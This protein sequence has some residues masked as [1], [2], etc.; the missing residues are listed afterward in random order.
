M[1]KVS[2]F[3]RQETT[4]LMTS[5]AEADRRFG[6]KRPEAGVWIVALALRLRGSLTI[7]PGHGGR[8]E[9][10]RSRDFHGGLG[11]SNPVAERRVR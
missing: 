5:T 2:P 6:A 3:L 1:M 11:C 10:G 7:M 8:T 9:L 4:G